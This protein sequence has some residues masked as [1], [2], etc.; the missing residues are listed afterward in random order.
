MLRAL[1]LCS[2]IS[3]CW[4]SPSRSAPSRP[5]F[6]AD[7]TCMSAHNITP[8]HP[9]NPSHT[10]RDHTRNSISRRSLVRLSPSLVGLLVRRLLFAPPA[11]RSSSQSKA[12]HPRTSRA[13]PNRI[14][15]SLLSA[16]PPPPSPP[17]LAHLALWD[18]ARLRSVRI[19]RSHT[20]PA[21]LLSSPA[22][23][24]A[25]SWHCPHALDFPCP[26]SSSPLQYPSRPPSLSLP[27][28][29]RRGAAG[30]GA[31]HLPCLPDARPR[32]PRQRNPCPPHRTVKEASGRLEGGGTCVSFPLGPSLLAPCLMPFFFFLLLLVR[33]FPLT[34]SES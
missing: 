5:V 25:F 21:P 16:F 33:L 2:A 32:A 31:H 26:P 20:T 14:S 30:G 6:D 24:P 13:S 7:A 34:P 15:T 4:P 29:A 17:S 9:L 8:K 28:A 27:R 22:H 1:C 19:T 18:G 3:S 23:H 12:R 11:R 10:P